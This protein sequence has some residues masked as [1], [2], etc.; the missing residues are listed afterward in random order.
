VTRQ[1]GN[2][3]ESCPAESWRHEPHSQPSTRSERPARTTPA[4][5]DSHS[6]LPRTAGGPT[7][8]LRLRPATQRTYRFHLD[9]LRAEFGK[10]RLSAITP[11]TVAVYVARQEAARAAGW[12]LR[13]RL[14]VLSAVVAYATRY[15]GYT[16]VNPVSALDRV[17]RPAVDNEAPKRILTDSELAALLEAIDQPHRLLFTMLAETGAR[18]SEVA[19]LVWRNI[20]LDGQTITIDGQLDRATAARVPTK[21][22]RSNRT[23]VITPALAQKLREYNLQMGRPAEHDLVFRRPSGQ[24]Y[25]SSSVDRV[26]RTARRR[27]GLDR[28]EHN[29]EVIARAPSPHDLRHT[30]ASRLIAAGWDLVEVAARLGDTIETVMSEYAHAFDE[31][32]RRG[33]QRDRLSAIYGSAMSP[34]QRSEPQQ[35]NSPQVTEVADLRAI[36]KE[37]R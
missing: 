30:H 4:T 19:G 34:N 20:N 10:T 6:T 14:T 35:S 13:G 31:V 15:L 1:D 28:I 8:P 12:T 9:L 32:S 37:A 33:E 27:V 21:T 16:G 5:R 25:H 23:L 17:E 2:D 36:R 18:K 26:M 22:R 29:G 24:A 3:G 11:A 7:E